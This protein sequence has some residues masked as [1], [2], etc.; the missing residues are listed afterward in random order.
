MGYKE[1]QV[2]RRLERKEFSDS[3]KIYLKCN[4]MKQKDIA[5]VMGLT[6]HEFTHFLSGRQCSAPSKGI[7][8]YHEFELMVCGILGI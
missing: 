3:V 6:R 8:N 1:N 4:L 5:E 7:N 2:Q